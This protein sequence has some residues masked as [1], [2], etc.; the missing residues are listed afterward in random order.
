[1]GD[2]RFLQKQVQAMLERVSGNKKHTSKPVAHCLQ[3]F[4]RIRL[5]YSIEL[6]SIEI[7]SCLGSAFLSL[8]MI[9]RHHT[10]H[11][12]NFSPNHPQKL[13]EPED[14]R[15]DS[16]LLFVLTPTLNIFPTVLSTK[17]LC[18]W[19]YLTLLGNLE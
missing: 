16:F 10:L 19:K 14:I 8:A 1:V 6:P 4:C 5:Q 12:C 11:T 13:H 17:V 2:L 7:Q 9:Y 3:L 18:C 15:I